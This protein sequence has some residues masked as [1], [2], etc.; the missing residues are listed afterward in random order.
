MT[1]KQAKHRYWKVFIPSMSLY[2]VST[3]VASLFIKS[4][5]LPLIIQIGLALIPSICILWFIWGHGRWILETDEFQRYREMKAV[6]GGAGLT[7][8]FVSIWGFMEMLVNAP[9]FPVFYIFV[10][11]CGAYSLSGC[12]I[13]L[14]GN[15]GMAMHDGEII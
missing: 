1:P 15:G 3:F 7:L 6:M 14:W 4:G 8:A 5:D 10:I 13:R 9:K 2:L 11:F 12:A